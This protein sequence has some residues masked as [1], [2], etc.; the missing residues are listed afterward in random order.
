MVLSYAAHERTN[1]LFERDSHGNTLLH[2]CVMHDLQDMYKHVHAHA[3]ALI[4]NQV[5]LACGD[6]RLADPEC[7]TA[8]VLEPVLAAHYDYVNSQFKEAYNEDDDFN[9]SCPRESLLPVP[10]NGTFDD[11]YMDTATSQKV[12]ERLT[13]SL[14]SELHSPL[15]FAASLGNIDMLAFLIDQLKVERWTYGPVS[16]SL[17]DL[18]GMERPHNLLRYGRDI[19]ESAPNPEL[20][21][22]RQVLPRS[23]S[24]ELPSVTDVYVWGQ[25]R[26]LRVHGAIEWLCIAYQKN[27]DMVEAFANPFIQDLINSKWDRSAYLVFERDALIASIITFLLT[28]ISCVINYEPT[29]RNN[30]SNGSVLL[31]VLYP[32]LFCFLGLL[33]LKELPQ[34]LYYRLDYW[35]FFGGRF[36][37]VFGVPLFAVCSPLSHCSHLLQAYAGQLFMRRS[38]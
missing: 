9:G 17:V 29:V 25:P 8:P 37:V 26:G 38:A 30:P 15:T 3:F 27:G 19:T 32:V 36:S 20:V 34:V 33:V 4:R 18:D 7:L 10:L 5:S 35:G 6:A 11:E 22:L 2:L 21:S 28:L 1:A 12:A 13:L 14:N 24:R 31:A 23:V 16:V